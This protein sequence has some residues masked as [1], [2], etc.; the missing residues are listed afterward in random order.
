M[1]VFVVLVKTIEY[2][3]ETTDQPSMANPTNN[4]IPLIINEETGLLEFLDYCDEKLVNPGN[5]LKAIFPSF[6]L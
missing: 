3:Q 2:G 1:E 6:V 4:V 5:R